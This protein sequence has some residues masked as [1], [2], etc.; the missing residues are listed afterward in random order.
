MNTDEKPFSLKMVLRGQIEA[1]LDMQEEIDGYTA[2]PAKT[3][4]AE[5]REIAQEIRKIAET[6]AGLPLGK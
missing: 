6:I 4:R 1:L 3:R 2:R 5:K